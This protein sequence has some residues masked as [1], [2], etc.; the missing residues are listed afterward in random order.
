MK[1][2]IN[3][4]GSN[5]G[6]ND[7]A[8]S[9]TLLFIINA[10]PQDLPT[11]LPKRLY[12]ND[13]KELKGSANRLKAPDRRIEHRNARQMRRRKFIKEADINLDKYR[14]SE[15][16]QKKRKKAQKQRWLSINDKFDKIKKAKEAASVQQKSSQRKM[17]IDS[18]DD[19]DDDDNEEDQDKDDEDINQAMDEDNQEDTIQEISANFNLNLDVFDD[20]EKANNDNNR[21]KNTKK[22]IDDPIF[23]FK[24]EDIDIMENIEDEKQRAS[25]M[26]QSPRFI[27]DGLHITF[28][29]EMMDPAIKKYYQIPD[30][31]WQYSWDSCKTRYHRVTDICLENTF[32]EFSWD[33]DKVS[34]QHH[35][36]AMD[37]FSI[38]KRVMYVNL[39]HLAPRS[40]WYTFWMNPGC[41]LYAI[42]IF[43]V[44]KIDH[45]NII[46]EE[47]M[48][49]LEI[50]L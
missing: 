46:D 35:H 45:F 41:Q 5:Y 7:K 18:D 14:L 15:A 26:E 33:G 34:V 6:T 32:E 47:G 38:Y 3:N 25:V 39:V 9:D 28:D 43:R 30:S 12:D 19:D 8:I 10:K 29:L 42:T 16:E 2:I 1:T 49:K 50:F 31:L 48:L 23:E 4:L 21:N 11:A 44:L 22:I 24:P 37:I 36:I 13:G 27:D 40:H 17:I 20:E